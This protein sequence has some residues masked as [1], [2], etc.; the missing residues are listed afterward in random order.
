MSRGDH[1]PGGGVGA[2]PSAAGIVGGAAGGAGTVAT[3]T[4]ATCWRWCQSRSSASPRDPPF[5]RSRRDR[6]SRTRP[7]MT[8]GKTRNPNP[9]PPPQRPPRQPS[10][11]TARVPS[12]STRSVARRRR[13]RRRG[14]SDAVGDAGH[15]DQCGDRQQRHADSDHPGSVHLDAP[16]L[17][18]RGW[19]PRSG[20]RCGGV[21]NVA[22][23]LVRAGGRGAH[24]ALPD[25]PHWMGDG[26]RP[27]PAAGR[28]RPGRARVARAGP[29][30][31]GLRRASPS[32][33]A[34]R[35]SRPPVGATP[36]SWCSTCRCR[37]STA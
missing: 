21:V 23:R 9:G 6:N 17:V 36:T 22:R 12:S 28:G 20:R 26:C 1:A 37:S 11:T 18:V 14:R 4:S 29:R 19:T 25:L 2:S 8:S 7:M 16:S 32:A 15:D 31:R 34:P 13:P 27:H 3:G 35:R 30:A 24:R 5:Q 33:T 10:T